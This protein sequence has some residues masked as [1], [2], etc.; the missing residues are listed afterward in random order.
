LTVFVVQIVTEIELDK[1][2]SK[3]FSAFA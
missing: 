1:F 3:V 2:G